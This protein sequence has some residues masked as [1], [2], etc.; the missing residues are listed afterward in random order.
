MKAF[1]RKD[2]EKLVAGQNYR[3]VSLYL[4]TATQGDGSLE[5]PA[6]LQR[7]LNQA[8]IQ[9]EQSGLRENA[10]DAVLQPARELLREN[11]FWQLQ[12]R[13][14]ALFL[15]SG[16]F[17]GFQLPYPVRAR[18]VVAPK[19]H[20]KTLLPL[21]ADNEHFFVLS[22]GPKAVKL[23]R[24]T[25][26][27]I[28]QMPL[29]DT[30]TS[31]VEALPHDHLENSAQIY[32]SSAASGKKLVLRAFQ[33]MGEAIGKFLAPETA[34]LLLASSDYYLPL[35]RKTNRYPHLAGPVLTGDPGDIPTD[36]L[37]DQSWNLLQPVLQKEQQRARELV[38]AGINAN[39][40][41]D[42]LATSVNAACHGRADKCF[43]ALNRE[44]WGR[45]DR[46]AGK[47]EALDAKKFEA[48]DLLDLAGVET[49]LR[50][51]DVYPM[52][53][54]MSVP[55]SGPLSVLLRH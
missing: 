33:E 47:V 35:L 44:V 29:D 4:P 32:S 34:P 43:V 10:A 54:E 14:L 53:D 11:P 52:P 23:F 8:K 46:Q 19:F 13:G 31:R 18:A 24:V 39:A 9:L 55:G 16:F 48:G 42:D 36:I 41:T 6:Q 26:Y 3:C 25:R 37:R 1:T 2:L 17:E 5:N 45:Y 51:G 27:T 21:L 40:A 20:L 28:W 22:V 49:I 7:L 12:D 15:S 50:G 30:I 38:E